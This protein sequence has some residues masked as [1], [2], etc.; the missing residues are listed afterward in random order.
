MHLQ[1]D[2]ESFSGHI[3]YPLPNKRAIASRI[4]Y[5]GNAIVF[6]VFHAGKEFAVKKVSDFFSATQP[7]LDMLKC[8]YNKYLKINFKCTSRCIKLSC[9]YLGN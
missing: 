9:M 1:S 6:V 8:C 4:G 2:L 3:Q 5:G 7:H